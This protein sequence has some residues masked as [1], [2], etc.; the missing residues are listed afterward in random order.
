MSCFL[1]SITIDGTPATKTGDKEKGYYSTSFE[2]YKYLKKQISDKGLKYNS[3]DNKLQMI[4]YLDNITLKFGA[5]FGNDVTK[6]LFRKKYSLSD[7]LILKFDDIWLSQLI[8]INER[9]FLLKHNINYT[10][11]IISL[12]QK[13][14]HLRSLMNNFIE[15]EGDYQFL[16][17]I[18]LHLKDKYDDQLQDSFT[19]HN[20]SKYEYISD[21]V[22]IIGATI[23]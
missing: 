3:N 16:Y 15:S 4:V 10:K 17:K 12:C 8:S 1:G 6:E 11:I 22:Q 21:I 18:I 7:L 23:A 9:E 13:D 5:L 14:R 19:P 20:R 2:G